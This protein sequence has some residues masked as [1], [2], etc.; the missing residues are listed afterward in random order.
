MLAEAI[1]ISSRSI[2]L[3]LIQAL[4]FFVSIV[5]TIAIS[6]VIFPKYFHCF[7]LIEIIIFATSIAILAII[8]AIFCYKRCHFS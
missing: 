5:S 2:L 3:S 1:V 7:L 6:I 8:I 4:F